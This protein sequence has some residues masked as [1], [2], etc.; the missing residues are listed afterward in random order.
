M[1][2]KKIAGYLLLIIG[3]LVIFWSLLSSYNI[4]TAKVDVP[5]LFKI[6]AKEEV[7]APLGGETQDLQSQIEGMMRQMLGE[8]LKGL[9]PA[10]FLP[11]LF[12]L[13]A[14]SIF[15]GISI[16]AGTQISG[17]CIK[18]IRD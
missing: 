8:Q 17:L 5:E 4:F 1:P 2:S 7:S 3:L 18:L 9:F 15:A 11:K 16:F 14:W 10:D 6:A 13:M 12:N